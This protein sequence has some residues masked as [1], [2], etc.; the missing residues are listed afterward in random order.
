MRAKDVGKDRVLLREL[1][2]Y[3]ATTAAQEGAIMSFLIHPVPFADYGN[4]DALNRELDEIVNQRAAGVM[5]E[6]S[7]GMME[8][9]DAA[10]FSRAALQRA[11]IAAM[12]ANKAAA[13]AAEPVNWHKEGF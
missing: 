2:Y 5:A 11:M 4:A 12:E 1:L 8:L 10:E 7:G 9:Q 3:V 6:Y 13:R